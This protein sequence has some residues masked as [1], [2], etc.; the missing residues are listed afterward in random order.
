[1]RKAA[2]IKY[3]AGMTGSTGSKTRQEESCLLPAAPKLFPPPTVSRRAASGMLL[4]SA[5][6]NEPDG[7]AGSTIQIQIQ[8]QI[9]SIHDRYRTSAAGEGQAEGGLSPHGRTRRSAQRAVSAGPA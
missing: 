2:L 6:S 1:M 4:M 9:Q 8:I 7:E 3:S 5:M